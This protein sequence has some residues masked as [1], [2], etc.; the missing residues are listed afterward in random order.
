MGVFLS[1]L[2]VVVFVARFIIEAF[3][4]TTI[5]S[6]YPVGYGMFI[7][8]DPL[9]KSNNRYLVPSILG[10]ERLLYAPQESLI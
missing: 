6:K 3:W 8:S 1:T 10:P 5:E 2:F 9:M 4:V 7:S